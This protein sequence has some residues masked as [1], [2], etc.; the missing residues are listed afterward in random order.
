[1]AGE[2]SM[3]WPF[4]KNKDDKNE[5]GKNKVE[6]IA[7]TADVVKKAFIEL[8]SIGGLPF[9][10]VWVVAFVIIFLVGAFVIKDLASGPLKDTLQLAIYALPVISL[11]A[12]ADGYLNMWVRFKMH[13]NQM[14]RIDRYTNLVVEKYLEKHVIEL[15]T[16]RSLGGFIRDFQQGMLS[17]VNSEIPKKLSN[18]NS[19]PPSTH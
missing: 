3:V 2:V 10:L 6:P 11:I 4:G 14:D 7:T 16:A 1:M 19:P 15:E 8:H 17:N 13:K 9:V 18:V 12:L 5:G